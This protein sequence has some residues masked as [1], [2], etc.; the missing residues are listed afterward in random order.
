ML[1]LVSACAA[2]GAIPPPAADIQAAVEPK[3]VPSDDIATSQK[4]AD[5]YS[6]SVEAWGDR[7][8]SAGGRICRWSNSV[9]K[10]GLRCPPKP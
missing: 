10:L 8:F 7:I 5:D 2:S 1:S 6:A 3:P 9:Y 4:A